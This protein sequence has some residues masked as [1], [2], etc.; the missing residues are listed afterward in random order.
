M[1]RDA[2]AFIFLPINHGRASKAV[3]ARV[4]SPRG[5]RR[6]NRTR[7]HAGYQRPRSLFRDRRVNGAV[8]HHRIFIAAG[9][10]GRDADRHPLSRA[11]HPGRSH[12]DWLR[13]RREDR[14]DR[15]PPLLGNASHKSLTINHLTKRSESKT[16]HGFKSTLVAIA[17]I[18]IV[19]AYGMPAH[20][21]ST[22]AGDG[23]PATSFLANLYLQV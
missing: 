5:V 7:D 11:C 17:L 3:P 16:Q 20:A 21:A 8:S 12:S 10:R 4:V 2:A 18:A 14:R 9:G 23:C 13:R 6:R 1:R 19:A 15:F 22:G